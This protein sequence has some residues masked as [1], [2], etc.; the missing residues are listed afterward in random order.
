LRPESAF[1]LV[2]LFCCE[3]NLPKIMPKKQVKSKWQ[4]SENASGSNA[5]T[6]K[7][8]NREYGRNNHSNKTQ[9][10]LLLLYC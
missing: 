10:S 6:V 1:E 8:Q 4:S 5:G 3:D 7:L 2:K 9:P